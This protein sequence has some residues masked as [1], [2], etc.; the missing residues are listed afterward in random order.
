MDSVRE[1][2]IKV[3]ELTEVVHGLNK[4]IAAMR[5]EMAKGRGR[6]QELW[7]I[8][9][10]MEYAHCG[11]TYIQQLLRQRNVFTKARKDGGRWLFNPQQ[12]KDYFGGAMTNRP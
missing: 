4:Q 5:Y 7:T 11:R 9:D 8:K 2:T 3:N 1:L 10:V 12:V 6:G